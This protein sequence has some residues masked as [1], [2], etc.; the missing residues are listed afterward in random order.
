MK[1]SLAMALSVLALFSFI[2]IG[3]PGA[4]Q[5]GGGYTTLEHGI[6]YE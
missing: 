3:Q 6:G 1:K 5:G 2:I 4:V